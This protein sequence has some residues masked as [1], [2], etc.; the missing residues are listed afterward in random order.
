MINMDISDLERLVG[1][2]FD[3]E[4]F[5][6]EIP[7]IGATVEKEEG[8]EIGVE[9]FPD[10]PDLFSVE[11]VAKA[12]RDL[13]GIST[14]EGPWEIEGASDIEL[15][16]DPKI[17][18]I[19]PVIG[20]AYIEGVDIDDRTL[21]SIMNLQEKLH[22]TVGRKRRKVAI[23]IHDADPIEPPFRYWAAE[24]EE[25][26][27]IPLQK[28]SAWTLRKILEEHEK[29]VDYAWILEDL[30][31]YPIITDKHGKVLS[32]PPIINGELTRVSVNTRNIF[33]DC[34][35]WDLNA[36][37]LCVNIVCSQ[38]ISRGGRLR[39]VK[40][41]Y[42][43]DEYFG[44]MGLSTSRWPI[45]RWEQTD[46]NLD[47]ASGWLGVDLKEHEVRSSLKKMGYR[48]IE[49]RDRNVICEVPPWRGDILHQADISEDLAVGYGFG[50]FKG[51]EPGTYMTASEREMTSLKRMLR[52]SLI[53]MGFLEA[54]TISLSNEEMQFKLMERGEREHI[55][56]TNP[57]TTEHTMIRMSALPSLLSLLRTNKH[58]DLPQRIFEIADVMVKNRNKVVL[59]VVSESSKASFSEIKGVVQRI[60][61]DLDV[62]YLLGKADLGCYIK[63][64]AAALYNEGRIDEHSPFPELAEE[65]KTPI[66]HFGEVDPAIL[67]E[68][69]LPAP[70]SALELDLDLLL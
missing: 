18:G 53:G 58:R 51:K 29:G 13:K 1:P 37:R 54:T 60:L 34:T 15:V 40:V 19:R 35:G 3:I 36:V 43:D 6:A 32:F 28:E 52:D 9:F 44:K 61:Q 41:T 64:R 24:P 5:K 56:I 23:G 47:W 63:G 14:D 65:G 67:S 50:R 16:V 39:S 22:I 59:T 25:V 55:R 62:A 27:F 21:A 8:Q 12:Y 33:V 69:E 20:A 38:L 2:G 70:V 57:I 31:K 30:D 7:M 10:R 4:Q 17:K 45:F 26:E 46:L 48:G 11:G 49:V 42:P 66:G 68:L